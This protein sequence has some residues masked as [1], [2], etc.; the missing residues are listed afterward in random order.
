MILIDGKLVDVPGVRTLAPRGEPW[1]RIARWN[2]RTKRPQFKIIHKTIA[3]DP[4]KIDEG[5]PTADYAR[6]WGRARQTVEYWQNRTD[7]KTG[8]PAPL[9]GTHLV[10]GHNGDTVNTEDL[11][12]IVGWHANQANELSWGHEIKE[13]VGGRVH[14][15]ALA[16]AVAITLVD[17]SALGVQ[18]QYPQRY[19]NNRPFPRFANGG[20]DLVGVFGHRDVT[21]QR[22]YHDPGDEIGAMLERVG[23]E[24]FDFYGR[25]DLDVWAK[26]QEWLRDLGVYSGPIDGVAGAGTTKALATLG[27][28][29]G[30]FARW[31]ELAELPPMPPGWVRP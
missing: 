20:R 10:T 11:Y 31:R 9:S 24:R 5:A 26:R 15:A 29:D 6:D 21:A 23:F 13:Y 18:W 1:C 7:L 8:K 25:E 14:R 27:F 19:I 22:G 12:K 3:D 17:T 16:A 4:E 28:P 30:I 2:T